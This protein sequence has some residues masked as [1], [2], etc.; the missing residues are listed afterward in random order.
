SLT[1]GTDTARRLLEAI[2]HEAV[3]LCW[4]PRP[5][6]PLTEALAEIAVLGRF[7]SHVHVF[8]WDEQS[9]RLPLMARANWWR[10]VFDTLK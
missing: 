3:D 7:V 5:G 1:D 8:A 2:D 4:Q 6:L 9:R 10:T